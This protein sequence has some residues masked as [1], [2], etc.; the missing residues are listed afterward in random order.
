MGVDAFDKRVLQ[1]LGNRIAAPLGFLLFFLRRLA[2]VAFGQSNQPLGC[3][4]E[5]GLFIG[6]ARKDHIFARLAQSRVDLVVHVKL[7]GIDDGH[8]QSGGDCV[9]EEDR[10]HRAAHGFIAPETEG[11]VGQ[12]TAGFGV[13]AS[14]LDLRHGFQKVEAVPVMLFYPRRHREDVGIEDN[15]LWRKTDTGQ[16]VIGPLADFDLALFRVGLPRF[17]ERHHNHSGTVCHALARLFQKLVLAF[18]HRNGIHDRFARN[19]FQACFD[20]IPFGTVDHH[21][22]TRDVRFCRDQFQERGHGVDRI[23]QPLVHVH[24]DNLRAVFDLI[25]RNLHSGVVIVAQNQF[26]EPGGAG[27]IGAFA[28]IDEIGAEAD[29]GLVVHNIIP[30]RARVPARRRHKVCHRHRIAAW[31]FV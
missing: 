7:P 21:R 18:L 26:L 27:N 13:R 23:Q 25:A 15:V 28:D 6:L 1:P 20:D 8:I 9:I 5:A 11:Q 4:V 16:Q 12:A 14:G 30:D 22:N 31:R 10:V 2:L 29:G 24:I 3:A 17:V 19:A